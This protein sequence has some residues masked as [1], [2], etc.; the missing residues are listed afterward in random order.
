MATQPTQISQP[1]EAP[2][3]VPSNMI[4]SEQ[5]Q[6]QMT[7]MTTMMS[8]IMEKTMT[9]MISQMTE[10]I[11][12]LHTSNN[13]ISTAVPSPHFISPS[14]DDR[15]V[16]RRAGPKRSLMEHM[17]MLTP[18]STIQAREERR[19]D[20]DKEMEY[21]IADDI[22]H[23]SN[24]MKDQE[25]DDNDDENKI[26]KRILMYHRA[27]AKPS[28]FQG[29]D[30]KEERVTTWWR[31]AYNYVRV[32]PP[33]QQVI[34]IKS[35]LKGPSATWLE[36]REIELGR[37]MDMKELKEG[38]AIEYGSDVAS[39]AALDRIKMLTMANEKFNT[40]QTYNTEFNKLYSL[41]SPQN[42]IIAVDAYISGLL[43]K[44]QKEIDKPDDKPWTLTT[45]REA[46]VKAVTKV[47]R[48]DMAFK[49]FN[50]ITSK[51]KTSGYSTGSGAVPRKRG[52]GRQRQA[53][54]N[55]VTSGSGTAA[56][57]SQI[58]TNVTDMEGDEKEPGE[59][60][61]SIAAIQPRS[62]PSKQGFKLSEDQRT[63]LRNEGRCFHCHQQGHMKPDCPNPPATTA[64]H[65][66][67]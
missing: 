26:D 46:A 62:S 4:T 8:Q 17:R 49:R 65:R 56:S 30:E 11:N 21:V 6:Q 41:L 13:N 64:P 50:A 53:S 43:P 20:E 61:P 45:V 57:I 58:Q 51:N 31:R 18:S 12:N 38:L 34:I 16:T 28:T 48:V 2:S 39:A 27:M 55:D 24:I 59:G 10:K 29:D 54:Y 44:Y 35:Y 15:N 63:M 47:D 3:S 37:E 60:I 40:I 36:S 14:H 42:Q 9:T 23:S 22:P 52:W 66:L 32:Y 25:D 67:K 7:S 33:E 5:L 19:E 1:T